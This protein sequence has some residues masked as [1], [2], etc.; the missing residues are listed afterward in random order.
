MEQA[1]AA[2]AEAE[3]SE[4]E[5]SHAAEN[6]EPEPE[7]VSDEVDPPEEVAGPAVEAIPVE[8]AIAPPAVPAVDESD[9]STEPEV[10]VRD[11]ANQ[12]RGAEPVVLIERMSP[13]TGSN[14]KRKRSQSESAASPEIEKVSLLDDSDDG[15]ICPICL[16]HWEMTGTHRLTSLKCGHLFGHSCIRRWL[17]TCQHGSRVCPQCKARAAMRDIRFIYAK[18]I[19][20]LDK[21]EEYRLTDLLNAEKAS[22][23]KLNQTVAM[24]RM[25]LA[26]KNKHLAELECKLEYY[27]KQQPGSVGCTTQLVQQAGLRYK[28]AKDKHIDMSKDSGCRVMLAARQSC[29]LA[30]SQKSNQT[31]FPGFGVRTFDIR[32]FRSTNYLHMSSK[33]VRDLCYSTNEELIAAATLEKCVKLF[34]VRSRIVVNTFIPADKPIWACALDSDA[35]NFIYL[36][37]GH[38]STY[39]YDLR[40]A[41]TFVKEFRIEEDVSPV[42]AIASVPATSL[43]PLGG[44][45]VCKLQ[46]VW[47]YEYMPTQQVVNTRLN[48]EG[49]FVSMS[50][51]AS[52]NS[53]LIG[54]RPSVNY[55]LARYILS[56][57]DK[58][59]DIPALDIVTVFE[60][61]RVA[62]VMSRSAQIIMKDTTLVTAYLQDRKM[63]N[64][65]NLS[66]RSR[67]QS[68]PI[69]DIVYDT[70]P[71]YD[72]DTTLAAALTEDKCRIYKIIPDC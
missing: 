68:L 41:D 31:L 47:F 23:S 67:S 46:S 72:G 21:S 22:S 43:F 70:C 69:S 27:Q 7:A 10:E 64:L 13:S 24:L 4:D 52:A 37:S 39:I 16:D 5:E 56:K 63:L 14:K 19:C 44:F 61:A 54:T 53:L 71:I 17:Q 12:L 45:I 15:T 2:E 11:P 38:G 59:N 62:P 18:R 6:G 30:I 26:M 66:D 34:S 42:I 25:E 40:A 3:S 1:A 50:Y 33:P 65:W 36:G 58:I 29:T 49:P 57:L 9:N 35:K 60:G 55:P 8:D 28:F 48:V 32:T 51:D 20:A